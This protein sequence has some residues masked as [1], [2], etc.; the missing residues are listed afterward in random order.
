MLI[1]AILAAAASVPAAA[2]AGPAEPAVPDP[3]AV[4][5]P[6]EPYLVAHAEGVQIYACSSVAGGYARQ[7]LAPRATLTDEN[8]KPLASH[9]GGPTWEAR[10]G[11]R[12]IGVHEAAASVDPTAIDWLRLRADSTAAGADGDRLAAT[13][14][15]QRINTL[16]GRGH[17]AVDR[18]F[19]AASEQRS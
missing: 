1:A 9:Y 5:G 6:H 15:I 13:T 16:G 10:D 17:A 3:I 12:V 7:L 11:S 14:Y 4:T 18:R 2:V 8:G 19:R